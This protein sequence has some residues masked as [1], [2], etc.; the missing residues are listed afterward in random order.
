VKLSSVL[1]LALLSLSAVSIFSSIAVNADTPVATQSVPTQEVTPS[2][3]ANSDAELSKS[4]YLQSWHSQKDVA[5]VAIESEPSVEASATVTYDVSSLNSHFKVSPTDIAKC[6]S[7][8]SHDVEKN[9][10]LDKLVEPYHRTPSGVRGSH[11][12]A[13]ESG[14]WLYNMDGEPFL[15]EGYNAAHLYEKPDVPESWAK[16]GAYAHEV[17]FH[18][19]LMDLPKIG[20][21]IFDRD[22]LADSSA[23]TVEKFILTDD[24]NHAIQPWPTNGV[25]DKGLQTASDTFYSAG[26]KNRFAYLPYYSEAYEVSFPLFDTTT[27]KA[28]IG[29][30][31]KKITLHIITQTGEQA[32]DYELK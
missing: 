20:V 8:G 28:L 17:R 7:D 14:V 16:N 1:T 23:V 27:G 11:G 29:T 30:S 12:K 9:T 6:L 26:N 32:V 31:C 25:I 24:S 4:G 21:T 13:R 22:R 15:V 3:P 18:V 5:I 19:G 10:G 2:T